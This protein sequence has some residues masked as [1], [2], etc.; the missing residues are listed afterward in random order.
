MLSFRQARAGTVGWFLTWW[1]AAN[2]CLLDRLVGRVC[3]IL[4]LFAWLAG[5]L[6]IS[7]HCLCARVSLVGALVISRLL[8]CLLVCIGWCAGFVWFIG[9]LVHLTH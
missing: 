1:F 5:Y 6:I 7:L 4:R 3:L 8:C 2:V 9:A